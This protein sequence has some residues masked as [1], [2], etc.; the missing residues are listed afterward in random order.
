MKKISFFDTKP[1][2]KEFFDEEL[3]KYPD[4]KM[5]YHEE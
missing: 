2:D 5:V 4:Y 3:K 1:Y